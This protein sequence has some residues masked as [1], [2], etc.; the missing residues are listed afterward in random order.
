VVEELGGVLIGICD[1]K[2]LL[3]LLVTPIPVRQQVQCGFCIP[4][5]L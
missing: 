1:D 4:Q 2:D 3:A 5:V